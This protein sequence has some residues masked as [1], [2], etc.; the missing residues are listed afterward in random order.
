[1]VVVLKNNW[2]WGGVGGGWGVVVFFKKVLWGGGGGYIR[3]SPSQSYAYRKIYRN[4]RRET[5][6]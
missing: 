3:K 1:V 5:V 2:V 4:M 6:L